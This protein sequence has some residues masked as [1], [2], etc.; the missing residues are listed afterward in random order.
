MKAI[1]PNIYPKGGYVFRD[2]DGSRHTA[3]SWA[4]V[5][6]RV[7][8]YRKRQGRPEAGVD[9]EVVNQAC[10]Q[11]PILCSEVHPA[12]AEQLRRVSLK[13]R[14]LLWLGKLREAK[15]KNPLVFVNDSLHA[16]RVD[17][18]SRCPKQA[19]LPEGCGS[20][21]QALRA[22]AEDVVGRRA[23]DTRVAACSVLG[24]YLPVSTWIEAVTIP[25]PELH[26]ECWRKRSL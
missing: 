22:L 6:A 23:L 5:I 1:N 24:E 15:T 9:E 8:R 25:N 11:N 19:G 13:G 16:A 12:N 21:R 10:Q 20:C 4:G 26:W 14:I 7:K 17:V 2:P 3:D 18:C